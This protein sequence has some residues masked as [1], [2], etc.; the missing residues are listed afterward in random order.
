MYLN[1]PKTNL[2]LSVSAISTDPQN[3][4]STLSELIE[5]GLDRVHIDIMDGDF[6]PR[7]GL[8]PEFV[9]SLS[10][11]VSV[12]IDI[13][14][15]TNQ[16][17]Q[18]LKDFAQAGA[19]RITPHLESTAHVQRLVATIKSLGLEAG[20]ALNPGTPISSIE[21][22][23]SDLDSVTLMAINPGIIGHK[24]L[25]ST[26]SKLQKFKLLKEEKGYLGDLEIDGGVVFENALSLAQSGCTILVCGAG[27]IYK[28]GISPNE[29]L[30]AL[31]EIMR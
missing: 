9:A 22:V 13:H 3:F 18:F 27:T 23:I 12:P 19:A 31:K 29:N 20:L 8:Y 14:L 1:E 11:L 25:P 16:P 17:F 5:S 28:P 21:E 4:F 2:Q 10:E 7:L 6:V 30:T 24:F 15:M 26:I